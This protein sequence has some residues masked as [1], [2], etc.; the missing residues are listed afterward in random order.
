MTKVTKD[1]AIHHSRDGVVARYYQFPEINNGTT[2]AY[3]EF[4]GEHG[5][6]TIGERSRIYYVL[7][8][9]AKFLVNNEEFEVAEGDMVAIPSNGT[10]NLWPTG[11]V[12]KVL[13][14]MELLDTSK[15]LK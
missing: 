15:L 10:Y 6:R 13:L 4:R 8:G 2:V 1:E 12:V 14:V 11:E 7:E 3:A 9:S 5:Q